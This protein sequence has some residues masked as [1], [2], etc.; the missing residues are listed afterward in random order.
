MMTDSAPTFTIVVPV[1]KVEEYLAE[2]LE[3]LLAQT[4]PDWELLVVNDGSPD[5]SPAIMEQYAA[6]DA[7]IHLI[8]QENAGVAVARNRGVEQARGRYVVH[9]DADDVVH[10]QLLEVCRY[11][12][13]REAPDMVSFGHLRIGPH[14]GMPIPHLRPRSL[15][16]YVSRKP[17][18]LLRQR[19]RYRI[20][21]MAVM[22]CYRTELA[23]SCPF[24]PGIKYDDYP[25]VASVVGNVGKV[26]CLREPLYGYTVRPGSAMTS[27]YAIGN[28]AHHKRALLAIADAYA[29]TSRRRDVVTRIIFPEILKQV[30][31]AVFR[32]ER[33][34]P[35]WFDMLA[36]YRA[37]LVE[38]DGL[39]LLERR[40]HKLRRYRAYR[41]LVETEPQDL[42]GLVAPLARVFH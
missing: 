34:R 26:V 13:E 12:I 27:D 36:A 37:L 11:F 31:N 8:H 7:R 10:P 23:R 39:G 38:L 19:E 5:G 35:G 9:V 3:S 42:Q 21:L 25:Y 33:D 30:G 2:C 28:I 4:D 15:S 24:L 20:S 22:S 17:L 29:A 16:S 6:R 1:Y 18:P 40:G 41:Q 14:E 32:S